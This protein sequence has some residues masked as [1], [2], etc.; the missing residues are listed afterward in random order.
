MTKYGITAEE[1]H[2]RIDSSLREW[3]DHRGLEPPRVL[4]NTHARPLEQTLVSCLEYVTSKERAGEYEY[5]LQIR[6]VETPCPKCGGS[7]VKT[8]AD[9][10][11]WR[12]GGIAGQSLTPDVCDA[13]WGTG[14][15][16][17]TGADLRKLFNELE[18][19]RNRERADHDKCKAQ[20]LKTEN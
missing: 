1:L 9:T 20:T 10:S 14:D 15:K 6:C 12:R 4:E 11:T 2:E 8:Y 19:L 7:G 17:R 5:F 18:S 13:C 3:F 16:Y